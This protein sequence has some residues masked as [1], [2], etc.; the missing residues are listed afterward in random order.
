MRSIN[1]SYINELADGIAKRLE[2]AFPNVQFI[3]RTEICVSSL[4]HST[5]KDDQISLDIQAQLP[6]GQV[7]RQLN[8]KLGSG[9]LNA[10]MEDQLMKLIKD[11]NHIIPE[12]D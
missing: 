1:P 12:Q 5:H 4:F 10:Q 3:I 2:G 6:V 9:D 8:L 11:L 7:I